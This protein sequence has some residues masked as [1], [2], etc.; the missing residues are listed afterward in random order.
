MLQYQLV[1]KG[2]KFEWGPEK[3]QAFE[4]I[5]ELFVSPAVLRHA[6]TSKPFIVACNASKVAMG[7]VL[8]QEHQGKEHPVAYYSQ[9]FKDAERNWV[10]YD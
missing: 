9:N 3:Q 2:E 5:K 6:N 1:G 7:A 8:L 10:I 4:A